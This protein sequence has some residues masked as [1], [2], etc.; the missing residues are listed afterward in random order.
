[1]LHRTWPG[2]AWPREE[3]L[4]GPRLRFRCWSMLQRLKQ[5]GWSWDR[6]TDT[7]KWHASMEL[8][9]FWA[10]SRLRGGRFWWPACAAD[11][12]RVVLFPASWKGWRKP[13]GDWP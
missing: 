5:A 2:A 10:G 3:L 12:A 6:L 1:M 4:D 13:E 11:L 9:L 8:G 7:Q